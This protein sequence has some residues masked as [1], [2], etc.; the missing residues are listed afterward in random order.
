VEIPSPQFTAGDIVEPTSDA[1]IRPKS[2]VGRVEA[3]RWVMDPVSGPAHWRCTVRWPE[4]GTSDQPEKSLQP[5]DPARSLAELCREQKASH[6]RLRVDD[7]GF[8]EYHR[9]AELAYGLVLERLRRQPEEDVRPGTAEVLRDN[10]H[11]TDEQRAAVE[12]SVARQLEPKP[13]PTMVRQLYTTDDLEAWKG[14]PPAEGTRRRLIF[15]TLLHEKVKL[16]DGIAREPT[17]LDREDGV[18]ILADAIEEALLRVVDQGATPE[19]G[20]PASVAMDLLD[21][22]EIP[23]TREG[24]ILTIADR[25]TALA[26]LLVEARRERDVKQATIDGLAATVSA[27]ADALERRVDG[28]TKLTSRAEGKAPPGT[29][30]L[31]VV[32]EDVSDPDGPPEYRFIELENQDGRGI[33][34]FPMRSSERPPFKEIAIPYG[35]DDVWVS[36]VAYQVAGAATRPLM[37]DHPDY[38]FPS[39]R[40][41]DA[42]AELLS[43]FG[44]PRACRDCAEEELGHGAKE[45]DARR[46]ATIKQLEADVERFL[47]EREEAR[48]GESRF[49]E[50]R[51]C[52]FALLRW[53]LPVTVAKRLDGGDPA[54]SIAEALAG[55]EDRLSE[56]N[57]AVRD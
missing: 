31:V 34:A 7:P 28:L 42:V 6:R 21:S 48:S 39:E 45:V 50:E 51:D 44:I 9:G 32:L 1:A 43:D 2:R 52:A 24:A 53:L 19:S 13:A 8:R 35:R 25:V 56:I 57:S 11:L 23:R 4:G 38:V 22:F 30:E 29:R 49:A 47:G 18:Q 36:E 40:V 55:I 27:K 16:A 37:E 20:S 12:E 54:V 41:S 5:A 33:G 46:D 10:P 14:T 3:Q 17:L 15:D 26:D